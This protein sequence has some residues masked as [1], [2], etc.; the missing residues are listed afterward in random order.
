[1]QKNEPKKV[2]INSFKPYSKLFSTNIKQNFFFDFQHEIGKDFKVTESD[3]LAEN[4]QELI[5]TYYRKW[6][7]AQGSIQ[8]LL[9]NSDGTNETTPQILTKI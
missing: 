5:N 1:M 9:Q 6:I 4:K 2:N 3:L 7:S 8:I